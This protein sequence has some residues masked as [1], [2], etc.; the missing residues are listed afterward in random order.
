LST[1]VEKLF[2]DIYIPLYLCSA[3]EFIMLILSMSFIKAIK[4]GFK[5]NYKCS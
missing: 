4:K 3:F 2:F 1:S 5:D